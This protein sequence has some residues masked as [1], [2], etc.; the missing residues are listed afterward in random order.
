[1]VSQKLDFNISNYFETNWKRAWKS[2]KIVVP[3]Q[4]IWETQSPFAYLM[5]NKAGGGDPM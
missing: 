4:C 3:L 2:A 1:M 5:R